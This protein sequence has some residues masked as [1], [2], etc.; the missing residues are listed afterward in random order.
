[1]A[2]QEQIDAL[3]YYTNKYVLNKNFQIHNFISSQIKRNSTSPMAPPSTI[4]SN[5]AMPFSVTDIL[6]PLD[7]DASASYKRSIE[8]AQALTAASSSSAYS[9]QRPSSNT[10]SANLYNSTF[11][12]TSVHSSY[13]G[14][15][16]NNQYYDYGT[17]FPNG[18]NTT[19][20]YSSSSCWYGSAASM[21]E[22]FNSEDHLCILVSRYLVGSSSAMD[23][24]ALAA[25]VYGHHQD[26]MIKSAYAQFPFVSQKRK[27]R[28]LFNQGQIYELERRFK[29]QKYLSAPER[30]NLANILQLTPTQVC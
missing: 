29:Q 8:M 19:G 1:M 23:S 25:S 6:Q 21:C 17:S 20:Q 10:T 4:T 7:V 28:I 15:S 22:E 14:P 12:P 13:Y 5:S 27:R 3:P 16:S 11:G 2:K 30:E 26:P 18:G 24:A 9:I